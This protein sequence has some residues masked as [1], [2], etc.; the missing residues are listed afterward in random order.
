MLKFPARIKH[1][2]NHYTAH[3]IVPVDRRDNS[4]YWMIILNIT[5]WELLI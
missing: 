5:S 1:F 2:Q 3:A 4:V